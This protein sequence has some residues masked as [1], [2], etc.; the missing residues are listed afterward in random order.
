MTTNY[1]G[2]VSTRVTPQTE[3]IP[4]SDQQAN[5]AG[6]FSFVVDDWKRLERFLILG[7]DGGTYYVSE[8][9]LT[10]DNAACVI[11][12]A[13]A[14]YKRTV[15]TIVNVSDSGRAPKNDPAVFALAL[16]ASHTKNKECVSYA[17]ANMPRVCR[18]GTHLF[19]FV[20]A[21]DQMRGWGQGLKK[22][23][24]NWY[25]GMP[26][27][28]L[29]EQVIKYQQREGWSH[30]DVLRLS[31]PKGAVGSRKDVLYWA[32]RGW[33]SV[34]TEPHP[35]D[36]LKQIWAFERAKVTEDR[37]EIIR[38]VTDY[39]LPRECVPTH[40]LTEPE[41][42]EALLPHMGLTAVVRNLA[43]MTRV[44]LLKPLSDA[45]RF[46]TGRV[47]DPVGLKKARVHPMALL[48]ALRTYQS[49]QGDRGQ[50]TWTPVGQVTQ[51]LDDAFYLAFDQVEPAGKRFFIGMD[52]SGSMSSP[53]AGTRLS[54]AEATAAMAL[55]TARTESETF[56]G[57]FC[58]RMAPV[59]FTR[60]TRLDQACAITRGMNFGRTDCALPM[61]YAL[62]SGIKADVFLVMTDNETY[63]GRIHPSQAIREYRRRTGIPAK[64]VVMAM[65]ATEFTIADPKDSGML[66]MVGFDASVPSVLT[67]FSKN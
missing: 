59:S 30:R 22:G 16:C 9:K 31:H 14:D 54:C 60:S 10:Q 3:P 35:D 24:A 50:N 20:S 15:D 66:D 17:L 7:A 41:V 19:Q 44:G 61:E 18:I 2:H 65:T 45:T 27:K 55:V 4:G 25:T 29:A 47:T 62:S 13:D 63:A 8:R 12:C 26:V 56:I 34:G 40:F 21:C 6:G 23:V 51:A 28:K 49:G 64:L 38:L 33:E 39:R 48:L 42:W 53:V 11:R 43:T 67:D 36:D 5:N 52:V 58:D 32:T 46:V 37:K 1:A 57:A